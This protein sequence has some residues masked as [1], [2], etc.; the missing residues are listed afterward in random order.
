MLLA[1]VAAALQHHRLAVAADVGDQF[2]AA[3]RA[4]QGPAFA[5]LRQRE[6]VADLG[7]GQFVP[8][9]ARANAGR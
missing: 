6:V 9:V 2:D 7:H 1:R 8:E 5:F 3:R 4:H